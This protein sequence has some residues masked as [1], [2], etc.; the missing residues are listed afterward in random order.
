MEEI[1]KRI[2]A[3]QRHIANVQ[4]NCNILGKKLI[5]QGK[6]QLGLAL[7]ANGQIH[8]NS[9][10][11]GIELEY[12]HPDQKD[13]NPVHFDLALRLHRQLNPHHV[14]FYENIDQMPDVFLAELVCDI[15]ARSAEMGEDTRDYLKDKFAKQYKLNINGKIYKKIKGFIDMLLEKPFK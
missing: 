1:I 14:E 12:L 3:V 9:K 15:C 10:L 2:D 11:R 5:E 4:E 8:D 13:K 6:V 7:I